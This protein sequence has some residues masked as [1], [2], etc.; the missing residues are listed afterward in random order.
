MGASID[1]IEAAYAPSD[2]DNAWAARM[3]DIGRRVLGRHDVAGIV[4]IRHD[5]TVT[6]VE[7]LLSAGL[8]RKLHELQTKSLGKFGIDAVRSAYYP[9]NIVT[10][11]SELESVLEPPGSKLLAESRRMQ[12]VADTL[13]LVVHP[14]PGVASVLF[15]GLDAKLRLSRHERARLTR[16]AL[17]YEAGLR[18]RL[19]PEAVIAVV[20]TS[21]KVVHQEN[22]APDAGTLAARVK[23]IEKARTRRGRRDEAAVDL[24]PALVAGHASLVERSEGSRRFYYV[25]ENAPKTQPFRALS[26]TEVDV[27]SQAA[28]G[29]ST[30]E[31][32][33]ALGISP[34]TVSSRLAAA[35]SKIGVSTRIELVRLAAMLAHDPRAGFEDIALTTAERDVLDLLRRGLSNADIA[36]IRNR[37]VRTIANQVAR[38]LRKTGSVNRRALV[39]R[40]PH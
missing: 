36:R 8:D 3:L 14:V 12:G 20:D 15:R 22:G 37:S 18:L 13:G 21:G 32:A 35:A 9:P 23:G 34:T 39:A 40:L 26:A 33:Y 27:V 7:P 6:H 29:L 5:A 28:R 30:K 11:H 1:F 31:I 17:H 4:T 16:L 38:L 2:D 10:T 19:A 25:L 24:W